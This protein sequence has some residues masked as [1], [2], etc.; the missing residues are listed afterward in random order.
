MPH[1]ATRRFVLLLI[2]GAGLI[3][4]FFISSFRNQ[5]EG[6]RHPNVV[7]SGSTQRLESLD[8]STLNGPAIAPKLGNE[9]IKA[10][11]G[12]AAWKLLHTTFAR[13][14]DKPSEDEKVALKNYIHLFQRLYPCGECASHFATILEKYPPQVSSRS[15]AAAW[16]CHVHNQVN[17]RL[18]KPFFDCSNIGDFYDCGCAETEEEA[19]AKKKDKAKSVK[20]PDMPADRVEKISGDNG[21]DLDIEGIMS[22]EKPLE[23]EK[24]GPTRG[25]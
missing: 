8:E 22:G 11:L 19:A 9:T 10:E 15:A 1:G 16:G 24:E 3:S 13:F 21:R 7:G 6:V 5:P 20:K 14:P 17:K 25:G 2:L 18:Q 4:V 12:R 23:L